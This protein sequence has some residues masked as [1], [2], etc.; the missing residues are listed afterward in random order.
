MEK[1]LTLADFIELAAFEVIEPY[2][3]EAMTDNFRMLASLTHSAHFKAP[4]G[5][6]RPED[7]MRRY[8]PPEVTLERQRREQAEMLMRFFEPRIQR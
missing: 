7:F 5:P 1:N 3:T 2:G 6:L 8:E 4:N